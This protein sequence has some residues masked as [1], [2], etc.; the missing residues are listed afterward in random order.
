MLSKGIKAGV[1]LP[2]GIDMVLWWSDVH[3]EVWR[4]GGTC[5]VRELG[6]V[7]FCILRPSKV[8]YL[9][10]ISARFALR[11][12]ALTVIMAFRTETHPLLSA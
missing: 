3:A 4:E 9:L 2:R 10:L 11:P 8:D 7:K 5:N 6:L 1:V 12:A